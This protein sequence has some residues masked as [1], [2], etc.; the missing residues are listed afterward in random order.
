MLQNRIWVQE[1]LIGCIYTIHGM[2]IYW[3]RRKWE[4]AAAKTSIDVLSS[5]NGTQLIEATVKLR[6]LRWFD[7]LPYRQRNNQTQGTEIEM[8]SRRCLKESSTT[9]VFKV[10]SMV[11]AANLKSKLFKG[12]C[13]YSSHGEDILTGMKNRQAN[14]QLEGWSLRLPHLNLVRFRAA[15]PL[16]GV[17]NSLDGSS[18]TPPVSPAGSPPLPPAL[19]VP[20]SL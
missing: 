19:L 20:A 9:E 14:R 1:D 2:K 18:T 11:H 3:P 5:I 10:T 13:I 16:E 7:L 17:K 4:S 8:M 6:H 12:N 15:S